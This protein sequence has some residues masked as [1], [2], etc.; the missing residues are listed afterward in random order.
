MNS[1][2]TERNNGDI[3]IR[4]KLLDNDNRTVDISLGSIPFT[5]QP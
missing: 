1:L 5:Y 4:T 3:F 2:T